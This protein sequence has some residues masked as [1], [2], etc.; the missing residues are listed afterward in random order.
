MTPVLAES[1]S[2]TASRGR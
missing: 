1:R 2:T